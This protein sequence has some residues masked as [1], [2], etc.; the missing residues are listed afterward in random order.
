MEKYNIS[1]LVQ[2][3]SI[4]IALA[5]EILQS[6]TKPLIWLSMP[7]GYLSVALPFLNFHLGEH[8]KNVEVSLILFQNKT[9]QEQQLFQKMSLLCEGIVKYVSMHLS[10]YKWTSQFN[11]LRPKQNKQL[12]A[13][14]ILKCVFSW[15][16][17]SEN[18]FNFIEM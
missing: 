17:M 15:M 18:W 7:Y 5:M 4:S 9:T 16:K 8:V 3:C 11:T 2:D 10:V 1:G 13:D 14:S 12:C 6:C